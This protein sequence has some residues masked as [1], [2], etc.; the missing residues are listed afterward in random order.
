MQLPPQL[1]SAKYPHYMGKPAEQA[2]TPTAEL[3]QWPCCVVRAAT[4]AL[5]FLPVR[6]SYHSSKELGRLYDL[7]KLPQPTQPVAVQYDGRLFAPG[8]AAHAREAARQLAWY[9]TRL[10]EVMTQYGVRDEAALL[11]GQVMRCAPPR[12]ARTA[13]A[14]AQPSRRARAATRPARCAR[15]AVPPLRAASSLAQP[16]S[17]GRLPPRSAPL[18]RSPR[19]CASTTCSSAARSPSAGCSAS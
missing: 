4:R 17:H 7:V 1:R 9:R 19:M 10:E 6:Q 8:C 5:A 3:V 15:A 13:C 12:P 16:S 18:K 14:A 11:S 2:R